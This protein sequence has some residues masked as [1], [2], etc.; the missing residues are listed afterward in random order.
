[1]N[2]VLLYLVMLPA[3][4]WARLGADIPQLRALLDARLRLD[5]RRPVNGITRPGAQRKQK[6]FSI[7]LSM[8]MSLL[9]GVIYTFALSMNDEPSGLFCYFCIFLLMLSFL[10]IS[11]FSN[12]LVDTRD[13]YIVLPAPVS[14]RTLFLAR[15]L[16]IGA[17][18]LRIVL[19]MAVPGMVVL[20]MQHGLGAAVWFL[21]PVLLLAA[22]AL[23]LVLGIYLLILRI[24]SQ[25]RFKEILTYFQ[26]VF[27][28]LV[29]GS[30]YLLP[31]MIDRSNFP[32][33]LHRR[34]D[35]GA[36]YAAVLA[37]EPVFLGS[38]QGIGALALGHCRHPFPARLHVPQHPGAGAA[39]CRHTRRHGCRRGG[40]AGVPGPR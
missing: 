6:R 18:L 11:D 25:Q 4:L 32:E 28:I 40:R 3:P 24:A 8:F 37:D 39:F 5:D 19:P 7:L 34:T 2:R 31:R 17:Y 23:F 14:G 30:Y 1:M 16:H 12:V 21:L 20:G 26:I 29:F 36:L 13:K 38:P 27:S 22:T 15:I 9:S 33:L 35:L 10:L